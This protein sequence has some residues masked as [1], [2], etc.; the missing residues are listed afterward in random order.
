M[1]G[2]STPL[3][4]VPETQHVG[5]QVGGTIYKPGNRTLI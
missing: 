2:L 1:N 5:T 3:K 4:E